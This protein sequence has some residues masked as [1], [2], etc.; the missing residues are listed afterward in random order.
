MTNSRED[1]E[2]AGVGAINVPPGYVLVPVEP[3]EA[4]LDAFWR[5][6]GES[7]QMRGRTHLSAYWYWKRMLEAAQPN[8]DRTGDE[9]GKAVA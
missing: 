6:S 7:Q 2:R 3:T 9:P 8:G 5:Q 1:T 4:V